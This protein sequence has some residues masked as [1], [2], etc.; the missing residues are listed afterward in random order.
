MNSDRRVFVFFCKQNK[1]KDYSIFAGKVFI[2]C[3]R[4]YIFILST[5]ATDLR[6]FCGDTI[7]FILCQNYWLL[8]SSR[9]RKKTKQICHIVNASLGHECWRTCINIREIW[10]VSTIW[11]CKSSY[12]HHCDEKQFTVLGYYKSHLTDFCY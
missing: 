2:P 1:S 12:M 6:S 3:W 8:K 7:F 4:C 11:H 5:L 10:V 9:S